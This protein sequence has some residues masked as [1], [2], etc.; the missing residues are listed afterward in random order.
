M[1]GW[2]RCLRQGL[3]WVLVAMAAPAQADT[4][5]FE[6][7]PFG[8]YRV[9]GEFDVQDEQGTELRSADLEGDVSW[10]L[11]LALYRDPNGFYEL[12]YSRQAT[13][14]DDRDP[15]LDG[16]DITTEYYHVGGT[17]VFDSETRLRPYLSLTLGLT[18]FDADGFGSE[19]KFSGSL[20]LG[21]R[22]PVG[23]RVA[24]VIGV[25][26]YGTVVDSDTEFLCATGNG[27][28]TCLVRASGDVI[29]QGEATLG[30]ALRF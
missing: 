22:L 3:L 27:E 14:F 6:I 16:V 24:F 12:L 8:G 4:P 15:A 7:V 1:I 30:I 19:Y 28:G 18:R 17:L 26:G 10:G 5:V 20:G 13:Q 9:G 11:D 25:R 21:L 2:K 23:Q 29:W